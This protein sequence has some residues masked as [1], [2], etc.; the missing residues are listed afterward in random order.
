MRLIYLDANLRNNTGHYAAVCRS[1]CSAIKASSIEVVVLSHVE[2]EKSIASELSA[3]RV[4]HTTPYAQT[5]TDPL[6]GWLKSFFDT[7]EALESDLNQIDGWRESDRLHYDT[8]TPSSIF[9]LIRWAQNKFSPAACPIITMSCGEYPGIVIKG[10]FPSANGVI[11]Y[12]T[13]SQDPILYRYASTAIRHEYINK[14]KFVC[15]DQGAL[16]QAYQNV[17]GRSVIGLPHPCRAIVSSRRFETT[18]RQIKIGCIGA[19]RPGRG[20]HLIPGIISHFIENHMGVKFFV[21]DSR[22]QMQEEMRLI[23]KLASDHPRYLEFINRNL[24]ESEWGDLLEQCN[25]LFAP[26]D[27]E[28][29]STVPSGIAIESIAY[30]IP[31]VMTRNYGMQIIFQE[32]TPAVIL[33]DDYSIRGFIRGI[34]QAIDNYQK[35][36]DLAKIAQTKWSMS[37]GANLTAEKLLSL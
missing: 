30:G 7:A 10:G 22:Q 18:S 12:I 21:H 19:H 23:N 4:F 1:L 17:L 27:P 20:F 28:L 3:V 16:Q 26:Y 2:I 14:F 36:C 34:N 35:L 33:V 8:A 31:L 5:S 29:Y 9:A 37:H 6:C 25:I 15:Y 11:D 13:I 32:C 24:S